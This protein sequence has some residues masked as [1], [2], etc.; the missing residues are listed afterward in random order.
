MGYFAEDWSITIKKV[1]KGSCIVVWDRN[2]YIPEVGK[3]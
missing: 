1:D 2:D 3:Y